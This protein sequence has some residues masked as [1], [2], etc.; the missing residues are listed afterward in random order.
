MTAV[1]A[2]SKP[3]MGDGVGAWWNRV[4]GTSTMDVER[5]SLS[6][7]PGWYRDWATGDVRHTTRRFFS[8]RG[9]TQDGGTG[10]TF[11]QPIIDQ[12]EVGVLGFI[13]RFTSE[14]ELLVQAKAEPGNV[15][16][17]Q[18]SPTVQAT[19]SNYTRQHGGQSVPLIEVFQSWREGTVLHAS[20]Q[21]EQGR[22]FYEKRNHNLIVRG[23]DDIYSDDP[24]FHWARLSELDDLLTVPNV[25]SMDCRSILAGIPTD[26]GR[27][28]NRRAL[29]ELIER[30]A[31]PARRTRLIPIRELR[32]WNI[33]EDNI[34]HSSGIHFEVMG[35]RVTA[36]GREVGT[37]SQPM[38]APIHHS[39]AATFVSIRD[40]VPVVLFKYT[41]EPGIRNTE[42]AP[43]VLTAPKDDMVTGHTPRFY[44][45]LDSDDVS[46]L[47]DVELSE[48]GGRFYHAQ[49]RYVV[50]HRSHFDA[51]PD[52]LWLGLD[53]VE[54]LI[55][56]SG[57][58]TMEA[59]TLIAVVKMLARRK[60]WPV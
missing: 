53:E 27:P 6:S 38:I 13:A 5:V 49:C 56:H 3:M 7:I 50:A 44:D 22:W 42:L 32:D 35:V 57:Y 23:H 10:P 28:T 15:N 20:L 39:I 51:G 30:R 16:G 33:A 45:L 37:W 43:A 11:D 48:E 25:L 4:K 1:D 9:L 59:R 29:S 34:S 18:I 17:V 26:A 19:R 40:G 21:S 58:F 46:I 24:R 55:A 52:H 31:L 14:L 2:G 41:D 60:K 47:Y 12:P 54:E 8:V 36:H